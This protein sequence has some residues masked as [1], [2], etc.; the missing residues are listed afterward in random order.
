MEQRAAKYTAEDVVCFL[1]KI[2]LGRYAE[3]FRSNE[4]TGDVLVGEE[5][6]DQF[7][8]EL[9]ITSAVDKLKISVMFR[10]ELCGASER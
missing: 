2:G 4:I 3:E 8:S 5:A 7:F 10:R 1:Q 6:G 9:G